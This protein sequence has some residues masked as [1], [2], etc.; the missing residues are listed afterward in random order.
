MRFNY[1]SG[2]TELLAHIFE[3]ATGQDI[4]EYAAK[5]LFAPLGIDQ[6]F[7][8]RTPLGLADT[9][10]GL[11]FERHDLAK[12]AYLY[13]Q[14][15]VWDGKQIVS[16]SWVKDSLTPFATASAARREKYGFKWW[17]FPYSKDDPRL[18]FG[19]QGFGGQKSIV[20]PAYDLVIVFTAWNIL[21]E[22]GLSAAE[23]IT[24]VSAAVK[25]R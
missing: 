25:D 16:P 10:G 20:I 24:R 15:G 1:N 14:N 5:N 13:L 3:K 6:Y 23:A 21:G 18:A 2:A 12:I 19:G 17:L 9:E 7:W 4:E 11:Y 8:K 22:K